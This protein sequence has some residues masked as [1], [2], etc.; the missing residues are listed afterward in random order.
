MQNIDI[1][2]K[3]DQQRDSR[4]GNMTKTIYTLAVCRGGVKKNVSQESEF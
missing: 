3:V 2:V 1:K 4:T